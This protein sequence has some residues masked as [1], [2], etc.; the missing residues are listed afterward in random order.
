MSRDS[1]VANNTITRYGVKVLFDGV[2]A[3]SVP[4]LQSLIESGCCAPRRSV[5]QRPLASREEARSLEAMFKVLANETRLRIVHALTREPDLCVNELA[6]R[7]G[8]KPQAVSNQ[9]RRLA[10]RGIL[11]QRRNGVQ[12]HYRIVDPCVWGLLE[13]G[14]CLAGDNEHELQQVSEP[15]SPQ[16]QGDGFAAVEGWYGSEGE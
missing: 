11:D 6:E 10:D 9:L 14:F 15:T 13:L 2:E 4:D 5:R 1:P 12:V 7:I 16:P 3:M 8:M